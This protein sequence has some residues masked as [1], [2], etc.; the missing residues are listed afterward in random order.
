MQGHKRY[1]DDEINKIINAYG[2]NLI[3]YKS[4]KEIIATDNE[5]YKYKL[6]LSNLY[7][8]KIPSRWM[9]NPFAIE[10]LMLYLSINHPNYIWVDNYKYNGCKYKHE[11]ICEIHKDKGIQYNS[12]D[13]IINN[14]H[15]CRYCGYEQ[16]R[17]IKVLDKD[18][19][20]SL[21]E[22]KNMI[23]VDRYTRNHVSVIRYYCKKHNDNIQEMTLCHFRES[24]VPCKYCSISSGEKRIAEYLMQNNIQ[25][26]CQKSFN[27]CINKRHLKFDFYLS[28]NNTCIEYDGQ[29]HYYPVNFS[30]DDDGGLKLF[31]LSKERD[32]LKDLYCKDNGIRL[33]RIPYWEYDNIEN[34]LKSKI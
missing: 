15:V 21:C 2:Y 22:Q 8:D 17:D 27:D 26:E 28:L 25:F 29:Q 1:T 16:L 23:Y 30:G 14:N 4:T 11:F 10:N 9:K 12:F 5:G 31:N 3:E 33:I 18:K 24:K 20:L 32:E 34:I 7:D 19:I 13:N 6:V